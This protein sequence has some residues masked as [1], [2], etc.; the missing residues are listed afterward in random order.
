LHTF[1]GGGDCSDGTAPQS[2]LTLDESGALYGTTTMAGTEF[3]G[4]TVFKLT[5]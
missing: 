5:P 3:S 2:P 1:C 4:G